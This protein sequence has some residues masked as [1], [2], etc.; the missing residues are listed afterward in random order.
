MG[1]KKRGGG[2]SG[3]ICVET[4][5]PIG[6]GGVRGPDR[7]SYLITRPFAR[8][9]AMEGA[10]G[11]SGVPPMIGMQEGWSARFRKAAS[12]MA[13][14]ASHRTVLLRLGKLDVPLLN[15]LSTRSIPKSNANRGPTLVLLVDTQR[16]RANRK[17]S[18]DRS[19][20]M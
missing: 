17:A 8:S 19:D 20:S 15:G 7:Q 9:L 6:A 12:S 4:K 3:T 18:A 11:S 1:R 5:G 16:R 10:I 14:L 2:T 13:S